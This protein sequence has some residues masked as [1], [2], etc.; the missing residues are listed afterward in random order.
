M[1]SLGEYLKELRNMY[2]LSLRQVE[3]ETGI[4]NAHLSQ[5]EN[6]KILY[7]SDGV[8]E[9]LATVYKVRPHELTDLRFKGKRRTY[10]ELK[11]ML[12]VYHGT[13]LQC[14]MSISLEGL[15]K[16]SFVAF[17]MEDALEFGGPFVFEFK[18]PKTDILALGSN[19]EELFPHLE[20]K[21]KNWQLMCHISIDP[22]YI[23]KLIHIANV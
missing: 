14:V 2:C 19:C 1:V 18:I 5:I 11:E 12:T 3:R 22:K 10:S 8:L 4:N 17:H 9:K 13:S 7:P 23:T 21:L 6:G 16:D 15:R 20:K